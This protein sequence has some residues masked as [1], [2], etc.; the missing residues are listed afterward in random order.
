MVRVEVVEKTELIPDVEILKNCDICGVSFRYW[1]YGKRVVCPRC[2]WL[3]YRVRYAKHYDRFFDSTTLSYQEAIQKLVCR[4]Q[5]LEAGPTHELIEKNKT[6]T[7]RVHKLEHENTCSRCGRRFD[8]Y[9]RLCR[10]CGSTYNTKCRSSHICDKCKK[11]TT[12]KIRNV[13]VPV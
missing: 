6:L 8:H 3:A 4:I 10:R 7:F 12:P 9:V 1:K 5:E 11:P 13:P 2:S